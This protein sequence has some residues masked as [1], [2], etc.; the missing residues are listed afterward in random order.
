MSGNCVLAAVEIGALPLRRCSS[1]PKLIQLFVE[2]RSRDPEQLSRFGS[3]VA[4]AFQSRHD[5]IP[6]RLV[7][8]RGERQLDRTQE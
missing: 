8:S 1:N 3:I 6:L 7:A 4:A 2:S 5:R